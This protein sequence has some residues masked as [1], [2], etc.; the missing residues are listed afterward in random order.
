MARHH[1][2]REAQQNR[3]DLVLQYIVGKILKH[4]FVLVLI[5][6][7]P[8]ARKLAETAASISASVSISPPCS[9]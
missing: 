7:Q 3:Y 5:D 6:V 2:I 9:C 1:H 4:L 8:D